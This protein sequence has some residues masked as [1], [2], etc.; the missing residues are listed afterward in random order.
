MIEVSDD[1]P[2]IP[3]KLQSKVFTP[4]FS[5]KRPTPGLVAS[6]RGIGLTLVE[7]IAHRHGGEAKVKEST[8]GGTTISVRLP[9]DEDTTPRG[10]RSAV[11]IL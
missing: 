6:T 4:G 1:G 8:I 2:G 9:F 11:G 5:T 3:K 7:R 10:A